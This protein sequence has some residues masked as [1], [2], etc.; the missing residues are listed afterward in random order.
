MKSRGLSEKRIE[1]LQVIDRYGIITRKQIYSF[2]QISERHLIT[3][4]KKL[5][6]LKYIST[7]RLARGYAHYITKAGSQYLGN[8][9]FGYVKSGFKEP[10]LAILEHNLLVNDCIVQETAYIQGRLKNTPIETITE[11][12]Q[13]VEITL[14]LDLSKQTVNQGRSLK[15]KMRNRVPDFLL[16][17][18]NDGEKLTNAYEV[19]LTRKNRTA[20]RGKLSW[21]KAEKE[22]GVYDNVLYL[23][24]R[25]NVKRH[26]ETNANQVDLKVFFRKIEI[27]RG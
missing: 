11:R 15:M 21:Y 10:N 26:I 6:A 14:K 4:L 1:L 3:G 20:L 24:E 7:Y 16:R 2:M 23:Y 18:E 9:N 19:E 25:D 13:L 17:F 5:E 22:K 27:E 12:E 8:I